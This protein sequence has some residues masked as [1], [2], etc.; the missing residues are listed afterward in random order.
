MKRKRFT[1]EQIIQILREGE[2]TGGI[3]EIA[4]RHGITE[5][6]FYRWRAKYG[7]MVV[8]DVSRLRALED[9]YRRLKNLVADQAVD[10]AI[11]K[12]VV[13]QR[14]RWGYQRLHYLLRR[15]GWV[16]NHKLL[17]R[18]YRE[19]GLAFARRR[20]KKRVAVR[21]V[22]LLA[23]SGPTERWSMDFASD[24]LADGRPVRCFTLVDDFTREC[25]AIEV[26]NS[27]A[28]LRVIQVLE[29]LAAERGLPRSLVCDNGPEF[30]EQALDRWAHESGVALQFI[31]P[32]K[33]VEN[34]FIQSFSGE[35]RD[36]CLAVNWFTTLRDPQHSIAAWRHDYKTIRP[37]AGLA[38]HSPMDAILAIRRPTSNHRLTA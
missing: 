5:T 23:P 28:A 36:E 22:P 2:G 18:L 37:H 1:E 7:G 34:T 19:E 12:D 27:L 10:L 8:N 24:A 15:E 4:R 3:R 21:R 17:L 9:E 6:T 11:L 32:G 14:P 25:P 35:F 20:G 26:A 16:M 29:R 33:P 31:Q 13:G 38:A 30:A